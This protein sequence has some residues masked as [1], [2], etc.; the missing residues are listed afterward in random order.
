MRPVRISEKFQELPFQSSSGPRTGCKPSLRKL[1]ED[2]L[3]GP[4]AANPRRDL[5]FTW[6]REPHP[7]G[8]TAFFHAS[9]PS[10]NLPEKVGELPVRRG[11]SHV[12]NGALKS[13]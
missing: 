4:P 12:T 9:P 8:K 13:T 3:S 1:E 5:C 11:T 7:P 6:G 2:M 10:A